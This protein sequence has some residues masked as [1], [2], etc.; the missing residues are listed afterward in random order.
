MQNI[1]KEILWQTDATKKWWTIVS[2]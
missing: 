1:V 2:D